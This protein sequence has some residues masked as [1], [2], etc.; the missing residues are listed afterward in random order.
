M[1]FKCPK[2]RKVISRKV[3]EVKLTKAGNF[4][5]F[6]TET[7]NSV[8]CKRVKPKKTIK[9]YPKDWYSKLNK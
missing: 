1:K 2:C 3:G 8:V 4:T 9:R 6:C 7:G 5:S